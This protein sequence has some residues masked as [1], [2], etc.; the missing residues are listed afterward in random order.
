MLIGSSDLTHEWLSASAS[1][2]GDYVGLISEL[3][4]IASFY[5]DV[6]DSMVLL[7]TWW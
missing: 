5:S 6:H 7:Y 2:V 3:A 1:L 4:A